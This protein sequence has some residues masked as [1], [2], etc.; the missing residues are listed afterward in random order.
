MGPHEYPLR[1]Q[2]VEVTL[3]VQGYTITNHY[4][5]H[6]REMI[7][8]NKHRDYLQNKHKWSDQTWANIAIPVLEAVA[9]ATTITKLA[10]KSKIAH[11]WLNLGLQRT[12]MVKDDEKEIAK[13]C[14]CCLEADED[15]V[16]LLTCSDPRATKTRFES[17]EILRKKLRYHPGGIQLAQAI[18]TWTHQ[19]NQ[20][21]IGKAH[22]K[23]IQQ[24]VT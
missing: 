21:P 2:A 16:H 20:R 23:L 14:P 1:P 5:K 15:F 3:M 18:K 17:Y 12:R 11:G 13:R 22:I 8:N 7:D 4:A 24:F 9:K 6:L 19:L 10:T